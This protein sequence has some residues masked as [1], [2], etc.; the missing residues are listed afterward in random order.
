MEV[1][2]AELESSETP[3]ITVMAKIHSVNRSILGR[4]WKGITSTRSQAAEDK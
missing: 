1:A 3:C 2:V 4:R